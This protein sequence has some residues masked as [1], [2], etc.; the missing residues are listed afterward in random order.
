MSKTWTG[1]AVALTALAG[2]AFAAEAQTVKIAGNMPLT[3]P[4]ASFSG[5]YFKGLEMG[6]ADACKANNIK[7]DQFKVDAQ[8]NAGKPPQAVSVAQKQL[9]DKPSVVISGTSESSIA[10]APLVDKEAIPHFMI[11]FDTF[12]VERGKD[13]LRVLPSYKTESPQYLRLVDKLKPKK[14]VAIALNY[15]SINEQFEAVMGPEL[16]K[17][18]IDFKR[19]AFDFATKDYNNIILKAK[20][21]NADLYIVTGFSFHIYPI[22]KAMRTYGIDPTKVVA[23]MDF[24]DLLYNGTPADELKGF[25]FTTPFYEVPGMVVKAGDFQKR[26]KAQFGRDPSFIEAYAYDTAGMIATSQAKF[27]K[28]D[29]AS[30]MKV[31]PY[32]GVTG[33]IE[34]DATGDITG[35]VTV[36]QYGMDG[37]VTEVK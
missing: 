6:L 26:Y 30:I 35:T 12:L 36:A 20:Q 10:I 4:I 13:R 24:V 16:K 28:V 17:R 2:V 1:I 27:G 31:S 37:K 21:E 18:N 32:D 7:C 23:A 3:G 33:R 29:K 9:L 22:I 8:D 5:N 14:V 11:A 15:S 25:Y 34:L 19:E